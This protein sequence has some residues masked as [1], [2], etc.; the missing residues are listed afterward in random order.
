MFDVCFSEGLYGTFE[1]WD[2]WIQGNGIFHA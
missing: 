1:N 2:P